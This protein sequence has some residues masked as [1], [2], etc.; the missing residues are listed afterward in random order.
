[1]FNQVYLGSKHDRRESHTDSATNR[2]T[3]NGQLT[4][5]IQKGDI[6]LPNTQREAEKEFAF[7]FRET[8]DRIFKLPIYEYPDDNMPDRL[9]T[10]QEGMEI[11]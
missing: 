5:L 11:L 4:W 8:D 3:A 2:I 6:L 1:M 7:N 10:A 9:E